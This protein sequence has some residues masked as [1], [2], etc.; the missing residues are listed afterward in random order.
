MFHG[1]AY[2]M[3]Y[4]KIIVYKIPPGGGGVY[5]QRKA[6]RITGTYFNIVDLCGFL[7]YKRMNPHKC[8]IKI[9]F[10]ILTSQKDQ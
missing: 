8:G 3:W 2:I 1:V 4:P 10:D 7:P 9:N 5:S 6:K